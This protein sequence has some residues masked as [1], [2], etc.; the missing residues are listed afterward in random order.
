M[1]TRI[2]CESFSCKPVCHRARQFRRRCRRRHR[3]RRCRHRR[4]CRGRRRR[5]RQRR[6]LLDVLVGVVSEED[7][8]SLR[9]GGNN[10]MGRMCASETVTGGPDHGA[11]QA[12]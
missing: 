4:H 12:M 10:G 6:L 3:G 9:S 8:H 11:G 1:C 2:N 7:S 5:F